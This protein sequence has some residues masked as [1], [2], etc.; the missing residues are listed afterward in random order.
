MIGGYV[1]G[2]CFV[3]NALC[4]LFGIYII[5]TDEARAKRRRKRLKKN[6]AIIDSSAAFPH[7]EGNFHREGKYY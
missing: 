6:K 2:G 3:F 7:A 4:I 1:L 5:K